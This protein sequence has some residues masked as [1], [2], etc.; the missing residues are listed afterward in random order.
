MQILFML[1]FLCPSSEK[2]VTF[3]DMYVLASSGISKS[4]L[5]NGLTTRD[6]SKLPSPCSVAKDGSKSTVETIPRSEGEILSSPNLKAFT[7]NEL[8]ISSKNFRPD[9]LLGEGGF[10]YVHKGWIDQQTLS[11]AKSGSGIVVAIKKLKPQGF[12]GHKEWLVCFSF[13]IQI[14]LSLLFVGLFA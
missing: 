8:K 14:L 13:L 11:P 10:G 1:C 9:S 3:S 2:N 7:F 6:S 4:S 12:Q 5:N